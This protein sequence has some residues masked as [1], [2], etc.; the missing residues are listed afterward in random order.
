MRFLRQFRINKFVSFICS[1]LCFK[2]YNIQL[3]IFALDKQLKYLEEMNLFL[4]CIMLLNIQDDRWCI[5]SK[6]KKYKNIKYRT[7]FTIQAIILK[8]KQNGMSN[9][10]CNKSYCYNTFTIFQFLYPEMYL[11]HLLYLRMTFS[12]I[13]YFFQIWTWPW[14]LSQFYL[15]LFISIEKK[16]YKH[17]KEIKFCILLFTNKKC[18]KILLCIL[19]IF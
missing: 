16:R 9:F 1:F 18:V 14:N 17:N 12:N 15:L 4:G 6:K 10:K 8:Q 2:Y 3:R 5:I 7:V 11:K 13:T 19:N